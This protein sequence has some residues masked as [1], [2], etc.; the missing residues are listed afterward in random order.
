MALQQPRYAALPRHQPAR[1]RARLESQ[2]R[3]STGVLV[4][5]L[6]R[7]APLGHEA[8]S[9]LNALTG[10]LVPYPPRAEL[11]EA[12]ASPPRD[13]IVV[14]GYA[15]R[16]KLRPG[17]ERQILQVLMPGDICHGG[18]LPQAGAPHAVGALTEVYVA[19]PPSGSVARVAD[20]H[21]AVARALAWAALVERTILLEWIA[22]A[23]RPA[24]NR[25]AHLLCE[26]AVRMTSLGLASGGRAAPPLTQVELA[27][28]LGLT[29]VHLNRLV[30][31]LRRE[32]LVQP[33][34]RGL[35]ILDFERLQALGEFDAG[36]LRPG[37]GAV[38]AR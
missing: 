4:R 31:K 34:N 28:A 11:I 2:R 20:R 6:E 37:G 35:A 38:A 9:A 23:G 8:R 24:E 16:Y 3:W 29:A 12:G 14:S 1:P 27:Q 5:N 26:L 36:Y 33:A 10:R 25:L 15:C 13:V 17:G 30:Q 22:A 32:G 19:K 21:E 7:F 18:D